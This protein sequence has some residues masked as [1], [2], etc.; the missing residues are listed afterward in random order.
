MAEERK[1]FSSTLMNFFSA[2][3]GMRQ[4]VVLSICVVVCV[5]MMILP[6]P[7]PLLDFLMILNT[8]LN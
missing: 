8:V 2:F 1:S 3:K 6:L 7:T 4:T 5:L